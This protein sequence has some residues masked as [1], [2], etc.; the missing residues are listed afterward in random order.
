MGAY[1]VAV[2]VVPTALVVGVVTVSVT[3]TVDAG[4]R[5][6]T[7]TVLT[8]GAAVT[9]VVGP[10]IMT[11]TA[12]GAAALCLT[13]AWAGAGPT[14]LRGTFSGWPPAART[15]TH[16][17]TKRQTSAP[18]ATAAT[19]LARDQHT[20]SPGRCIISR[21]LPVSRRSNTRV[22]SHVPNA[23]SGTD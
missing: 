18:A 20:P 19:Q 16:T 10:G 11:V 6:V 21:V 5:A 22:E 13:C 9:V 3:V 4:C 14:S 12:F 15:P 23:S 1:G 8:R 17:P 2:P 7:V